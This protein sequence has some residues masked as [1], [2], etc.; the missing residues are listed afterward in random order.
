MVHNREIVV[1]HEPNR[2]ENRTHSTAQLLPESPGETHAPAELE[3]TER[4]QSSIVTMPLNPC[5]NLC[6]V[7]TEYAVGTEEG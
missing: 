6:S 5:N 3:G 4:K 2:E 7:K 1:R